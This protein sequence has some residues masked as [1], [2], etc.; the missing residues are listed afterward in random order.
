GEHLVAARSARHLGEGGGGRLHVEARQDAKGP[1]EVAAEG[2]A[3][4]G[5]HAV[6]RTSD[7]LSDRRVAKQM[8]CDADYL[9]RN[10]TRI[11]IGVPDDAHSP[12]PADRGGA[13]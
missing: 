12:G 5:S 9:R 4:D 2:A 7:Q 1:A 3:L 13:R 8:F 11:A 10:A 6:Q